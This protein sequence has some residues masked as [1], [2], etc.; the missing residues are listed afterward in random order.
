MLLSAQNIYK[1]YG[2]LEVLRGIDLLIESAEIVAIT[3]SS[4]A[5][6]STLLHIIG[7]LDKADSGTITINNKNIS[8]LLDL[9]S[10]CLVTFYQ[11]LFSDHHFW[12]LAHL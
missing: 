11:H 8:S 3:G 2:D 1:K 9:V 7:T 6:K 4:G 5:G 12:Q 10:P